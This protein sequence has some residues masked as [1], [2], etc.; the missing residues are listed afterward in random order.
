METWVSNKTAHPGR[1]PIA[2]PHRTTAKVQEERAA[3]AQAK[4]ALIEAKVKRVNHAAEFDRDN[5][6]NKDLV[7][8]TPCPPFTPKPW[9]PLHNRKAHHTPKAALKPIEESSDVKVTDDQS[10]FIPPNSEISVVGNS[11]VES[12]A[13]PSPAK[14]RKPEI[15]KHAKPKATTTKKA[16]TTAKKSMVKSVGKKRVEVSDVEMADSEAEPVKVPKPKK[17]KV[18]V[19]DKINITAKERRMLTTF[20]YM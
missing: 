20:Y 15:R 18:R 7:D 17:E 8:A 12:E 16:M 11:E 3:K 13:A 14:K 5:I 10:L 9:P 6:A 4:A 19:Q 2:P 1:V